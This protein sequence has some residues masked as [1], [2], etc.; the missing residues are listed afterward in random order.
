MHVSIKRMKMFLTGLL[1][2]CINFAVSSAINPDEQILEL[3]AK[4]GTILKNKSRQDDDINTL[5][6]TLK[7]FNAPQRI[8]P[9]ID[10]L[11]VQLLFFDKQYE[12]AMN[13]IKQGKNKYGNLLPDWLIWDYLIARRM[14]Y[15]KEYQENL[16]TEIF[17]IIPQS[18]FSA[19][20]DDFLFIRNNSGTLLFGKAPLTPIFA[21]DSFIKIA[22]IYEA[23]NLDYLAVDNYLNAIYNDLYVSRPHLRD[24]EWLRIA[25]LEKSMSHPYLAK[26]SYM[27]ALL[28]NPDNLEIIKNEWMELPE[29]TNWHTLKLPKEIAEKVAK[30]YQHEKFWPLAIQTLKSSSNINQKL[31]DKYTS[32]FIE[33]VDKYKKTQPNRYLWGVKISEI[34]SI[35]DFN[36]PAPSRMFWN[37]ENLYKLKK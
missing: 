32:E 37:E 3:C 31:I 29:H 30:L 11:M 34:K 10:L 22:N 16:L 21:T 19:S 5:L 13:I 15:P 26:I 27:R 35:N 12:E 14:K 6:S 1:L 17:S 20:R 25:R 23:E 4:T 24:I 7:S 36:F 8:R 33:E 28:S 2:L 9:E 18:S